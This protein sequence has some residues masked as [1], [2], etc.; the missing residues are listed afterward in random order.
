MVV[1]HQKK[2]KSLPQH[3]YVLLSQ[4]KHFG[5]FLFSFKSQHFHKNVPEFTPGDS[6]P[7]ERGS[8]SL[9][10]HLGVA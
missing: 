6:L 9:S 3:L 8:L 1:I 7:E 2:K 4:L 10:M 5:V